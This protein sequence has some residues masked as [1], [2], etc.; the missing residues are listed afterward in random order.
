MSAKSK[1]I[2]KILLALGAILAI[3]VFYV[4]FTKQYVDSATTLVYVANQDIDS[5]KKLS[6]AE[7]NKLFSTKTVH[8]TIAEISSNY[9]TSYSDI[10]NLETGST[11]YANTIALKSMWRK[12]STGTRVSLPVD[13]ATLTS[14]GLLVSS[15]T[16]ITIVGYSA[17]SGT[18]MNG[19]EYSD[20]WLGILT[21][22]AHCV[23]TTTNSANEITRA[24]FEIEDTEAIGN[25][26]MFANTGTLYY[27]N[28][29]IDDLSKLSSGVLYELYQS[30]SKGTAEEFSLVNTKLDVLTHNNN[31]LQNEISI[32]K[33]ENKNYS[34]PI[35]DSM[36]NVSWRGLTASAYVY[37]YNSDGSRGDA[38]GYYTTTATDKEHR[39]VY[40]AT[41]RETSLPNF[42]E[43]GEKYDG[44]YEVAVTIY[45]PEYESD[46]QKANEYAQTYFFMFTID[47][48]HQLENPYT[49]YIDRASKYNMSI[50]ANSDAYENI[51][52]MEGNN[53]V[54]PEDGNYF[55]KNLIAESEDSATTISIPLFKAKEGNRSGV[56]AT[57]TR[58]KELLSY[59]YSDISGD[60][61]LFSTEAGQ[62]KFFQYFE[63][64]YN[65]T[66]IDRILSVLKN[67]SVN[68][69]SDKA[70]RLMVLNS[71]GFEI[72]EFAE[73]SIE[74]NFYRTIDEQGFK[75]LTFA[76]YNKKGELLSSINVQYFNEAPTNDA[77]TT[78][79]SVDASESTDKAED[80][81]N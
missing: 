75:S 41:T 20:S 28:G 55:V 10:Q 74:E 44:Y 80:S 23:S 16:P 33:S 36:P 42:K 53:A 60:I 24:T 51:S 34:V 78:V 35:F 39:L 66:E 50:V 27:I 3:A 40:N 38:Y 71:L 43:L 37:H 77:E 6:E 70:I 57:Q 1:N 21:N 32:A 69:E 47:S 46:N 2:F 31:A 4:F 62:T 68:A 22:K 48:E 79:P 58:L 76:Y 54:S 67:S 64:K 25:L 56:S 73:G 5:F 65:S 26:L 72:N 30:S 59:F 17:I 29:E 45:N 12:Q 14:D 19:K 11:I 9:V 18:D 49:A 63:D 7:F 15:T 81:K 52:F 13:Q 61:T 8:S